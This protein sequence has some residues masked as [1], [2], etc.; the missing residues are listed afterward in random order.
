[1]LLESLRPLIY[2]QYSGLRE[3]MRSMVGETGEIA[4]K[5][6]AENA[7]ERKKICRNGDKGNLR[8]KG[9]GFLAGGKSL[10]SK[11]II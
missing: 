4:I 2:V 3:V 7:R 5:I 11:K 6:C 1:M 9:A 10:K 8:L